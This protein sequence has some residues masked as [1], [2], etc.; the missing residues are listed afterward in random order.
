MQFTGDEVEV[1]GNVH[2][3]FSLFF[4]AIVAIYMVR[5]MKARQREL[6]EEERYQQH[7]R[8]FD[9]DYDKRA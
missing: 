6:D 9:E 7:K 1:V 4:L 8:K 5:G 2:W 3:G